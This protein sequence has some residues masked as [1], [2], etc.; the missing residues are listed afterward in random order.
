MT[1]PAEETVIPTIGRER[2]V[3]AAIAANAEAHGITHDLV[4][5]AL[6]T[7]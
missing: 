1:T 5:Q 4:D 3:D 6:M 2:N 7:P